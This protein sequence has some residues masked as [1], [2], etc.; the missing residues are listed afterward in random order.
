MAL[1]FAAGY[2]VSYTG[3]VSKIIAAIRAHFA[4]K[5]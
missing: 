4:K 3:G 1:A 5:P 2:F